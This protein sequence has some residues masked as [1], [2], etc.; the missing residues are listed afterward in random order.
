LIAVAIALLRTIWPRILASFREQLDMPHVNILERDLAVLVV[1]DVQERM[2]G[3]ITTSPAERI[4]QRSARLIEAARILDIPVLYTEQN[5]K[6]IGATDPRLTTLLQPT[7]KLIQKTACSCWRQ[8]T[9]REAL[10]ATRREH[11]I[12]CGLEAHV[13]IQQTALDLLRV[14]YVP[15]VATDAIGSRDLEDLTAAIDRMARAGVVLSTSEALL[16]ELIERCDDPHFK[17]IL[18]LVK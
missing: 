5:P 18:R 2:L 1:V 12:L 6:G 3:A 9:F 13:C 16:F 4:I 8:E 14:D 7:G 15:F 17:E 11:V 10:Q